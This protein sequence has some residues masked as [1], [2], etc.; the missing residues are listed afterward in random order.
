MPVELSFDQRDYRLER[1]GNKVTLRTRRSGGEY[2]TPRQIVLLTGSHNL[3]ILWSETGNGRTLE[4]LPFA[5]IIA[6][7]MWAPVT[8]TF[9]MP[10]DTKE[11][12]SIGAWNGACMDC[13]VTEGQSHFVSG[14]TWDTRVAEFGIAC[15]ACHSEGNDHIARNHNPARRFLIHLTTGSDATVT[16]PTRLSAAASSADCAQCHSIWAFN[17]ME[18]K[19]DFN[20]HGSVFRPGQVDLGQRFVVQPNTSD[21]QEQKD[22]IRRTEPD[23]FENRFWGD[24]MIRVTGREYNGLQASPCFR[25]GEFTCI[26][27]HEMHPANQQRVSLTKW[28]SSAQL[29]TKMDSDDACLQCHKNF[30]A[31]ISAHTHHAI[32]SSGSHCYNCH[33]PH[34][35]YGLLRGIRSHQ[36]SSPSVQESVA[37]HR[38]NACNLCHLDQTLAWTAKK[39]HDWYKQPI[40]DLSSD[41]ESIASGVQWLVKGDAGQR[42]LIAWGMGWQP[43]QQ[44]SGRQWLYPY[45]IYALND[46]YAAVRFDAWKSLQ[47]LPGFSD[48]AFNYTADPSSLRDA[49]ER[50]YTKWLH[51]LRGPNPI[52]EPQTALDSRGAFQDDVIR[53]LETARDDRRIFLAE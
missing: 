6:E 26:S 51:E 2:G 48:F 11:Y 28:A 35:T 18:D 47:T 25:G 30:A 38:P 1:E 27:C 39:L 37:Y 23:F 14:N 20:R 40:S 4:Q 8:Q 49:A 41:D 43:A 17:N 34:T 21:H 32:A 53:R 13:H 10:P 9:L 5:Y 15:E 46:P 24:G 36:V 22:F 33:M 3:Q 29:K 52:F 44:A 19:I 16:N 31:N 50:A 12:Y 45:L 7:K 42:A